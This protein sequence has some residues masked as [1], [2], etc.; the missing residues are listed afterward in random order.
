MPGDLEQE[1]LSAFQKT[2]RHILR[3]KNDSSHERAQTQEAIDYYKTKLIECAEAKKEKECIG[4]IDRLVELR[5]RLAAIDIA[6]LEQEG[7]SDKKI[8]QVMKTYRDDCFSLALA[9]DQ[10]LST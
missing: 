3:G 10:L 9:T 7:A 5:A 1:R 6:D 8:Q 2:T 4:M